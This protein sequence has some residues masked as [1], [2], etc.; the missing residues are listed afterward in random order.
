M[1]ELA[2]EAGAD[3][4]QFR[5]DRLKAHPRHQKVLALAAEKANWST[6]LGKGQGRGIALQESFGSLVAEVVEVTVTKGEVSVDKVTVVVD[7]GF[8]VSPDGVKAQMESGV[9]YGLTAALHGEVSIEN[10]RVV[11]ANF[12]TYPM[13]RMDTAPQIDT[14][15]I[16]SM[17]SWGGAGEPGTPGIAPALTNAIYAATGT[18]I[19]DLPVSQ[20]DLDV[21]FVESDSV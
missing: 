21:D 14:H 19:R 11:Q 15:I 7:A 2:I 16:N 13:V 3:P 18:R 9:L 17:E 1:D 12:D 8:A 4:Y 10:G 5:M 20:Y 6:P